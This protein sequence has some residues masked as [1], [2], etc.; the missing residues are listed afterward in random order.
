[1]ADLKVKKVEG[2]DLDVEELSDV[3]SESDMSEVSEINDDVSEGED[4]SGGEDVSEGEDEDK[5][6]DKEA[7]E[8]KDENDEGEIGVGIEDIS[9]DEDEEE[10]EFYL[11]K[12]NTSI[13]DNLIA[14]FHPESKSHN[15]EEIKQLA[16]VSRNKNGVIVD[17]LHKTLPFLTKY[18]KT[19]ILGQ[20]SKQI[21]SGAMPLV[22]VPSNIIDSY[23]IAKLELKENKIPFIIRRP[24]PN[25][26][27]E[28]WHVS[29]L[30]NI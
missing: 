29:D 19:R 24:L 22:N 25:G 14:N 26:G 15:Y 17:E 7:G 30:E 13:R 16:K 11:Q 3:E 27:T 6:R 10:D 8:D 28:Y 5:D 23:L 20:R 1:M 21:E 9:D 2:E 12:F 4:V 18:E